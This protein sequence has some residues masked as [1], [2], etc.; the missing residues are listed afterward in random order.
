MKTI[1]FIKSA[2]YFSPLDKGEREGVVHSAAPTP[3]NSPS[4]RGRGYEQGS[5]VIT[6][7]LFMTLLMASA[8]IILSGVLSRHIHASRDYFLSAGAFAGANSGME[9]MRYKLLKNSDPSPV[10]GELLYGAQKVT[11]EATGTTIDCVV[12]SGTFGSVVRR[13]QLGGES[14]GC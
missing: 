9:Q 1:H 11:Y 7:V 8:A 3:T 4:G 10:A 12:S 6:I 14:D 13:I 2:V 5:V